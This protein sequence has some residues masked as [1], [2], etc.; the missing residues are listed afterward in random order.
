MAISEALSTPLVI[1]GQERSTT[2]TF[3]VLDPHDGSV[4]GHAAAAT[5]EDALD[6]VEAAQRAWP[7]WAALSAAERI[8]ICLKALETLPED[9]AE[10]AEVLSRENGKIRFEAEIDLHVFVGR[11]HEAAKYARELDEVETIPG[12]PY[13]TT[14]QHLPQGVVTIIYPFNWPLAI[15]AASLP[16]ALMAGNTV[17]AKPPPT[18]PL[19][20]VMTLRHLA[21]LLPPGS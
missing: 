3:A 12:P 8:D 4:I 21:M 14:I 13:N 6:A 17:I 11:F 2:D 18:T 7:A 16:Q 5:T 19:S 9:F 20:S 1:N 15:L 10:R